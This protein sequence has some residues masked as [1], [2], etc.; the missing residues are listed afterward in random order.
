MKIS[1]VIKTA[2]ALF[3]FLTF[4]NEIYAQKDSVKT[5]VNL[6]LNGGLVANGNSGSNF[7][8]GGTAQVLI[9]GNQKIF[10]VSGI[11]IITNPFDGEPFSFLKNG[12]NYKGDALNYAM[13]L[14]GVRVKLSDLDRGYFYA[15]PKA[16]VAFAHGFA[17]SGLCV[18]PAFGFKSGS[19]DLA[20]A[21]DAGVGEKKLN[22]KKKVFNTVTVGIGFTF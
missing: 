19:L 12:F 15:E 10:F 13:M 9:P 6:Q 1:K 7:A 5:Y 4:F 3:F 2:F 17:W 16:G 21:F 18:S 8:Y 11:K 22:T 20:L 14:T